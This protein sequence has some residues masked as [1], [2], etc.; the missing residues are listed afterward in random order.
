MAAM[1]KDVITEH[2]KATGDNSSTIAGPPHPSIREL[3]RPS[4]NEVIEAE[5][6]EREAI[7]QPN[8]HP[9]QSRYECKIEEHGASSHLVFVCTL[10]ILAAQL[11]I[12]TPAG[13]CRQIRGLRYGYRHLRYCL[14]ECAGILGFSHVIMYYSSTRRQYHS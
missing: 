8:V 1:L 13:T 6:R 2:A 10:L 7:T 9:G 14:A 4:L 5:A 3:Y 11:L 12:S